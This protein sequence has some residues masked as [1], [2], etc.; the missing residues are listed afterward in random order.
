MKMFRIVDTYNFGD[1]VADKTVVFFNKIELYIRNGSWRRPSE[2]VFDIER[3]CSSGC[4]EINIGFFG[5]IIL[6]GDCT[7]DF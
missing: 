2:W 6:R 4:V 1:P 3:S 7:G 5:I